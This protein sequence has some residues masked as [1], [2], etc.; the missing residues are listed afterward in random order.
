VLLALVASG[1]LVVVALLAF[2]VIGGHGPQTHRYVIPKGTAARLDAGEALELFP[3][4]LE[5]RV[6]DHLVIVN[7]DSED[8]HVGPF[9]V[10]AHGKV[11][12]DFASPGTLQGA[13][14]LNAEGEAVIEIRE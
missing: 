12:V 7:R 5:V 3:A 9:H 14:A 4:R 6:G 1:V 8:H 2:G 13:C 11:E 10:D